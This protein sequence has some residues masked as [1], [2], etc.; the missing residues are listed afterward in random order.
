[1]SSAESGITIAPVL[2]R[3]LD[4]VLFSKLVFDY[5]ND[6]PAIYKNYFANSVC[7]GSPSKSASIAFRSTISYLSA[8]TF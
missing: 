5:I 4:A 1:M 7:A 6:V 2:P 3:P 8:N